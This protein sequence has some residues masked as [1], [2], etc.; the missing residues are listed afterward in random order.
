M[1]RCTLYARITGGREQMIQA[2][3]D[4]GFCKR[5]ANYGLQPRDMSRRGIT[6]RYEP[7]LAQGCNTDSIQAAS[8]SSNLP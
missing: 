4:Q 3:D 1:G 5:R 2:Y 8:G 7:Q 6:A